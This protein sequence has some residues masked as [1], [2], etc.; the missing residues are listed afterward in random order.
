MALATDRDVLE[1][2][3]ALSPLFV[4]FGIPLDSELI[5]KLKIYYRVLMGWNTT[6]HLVAPTPPALF[7]HRHIAESLF[8][9]KFM[10]KSSTLVDIGSG[11]GL[12]AM[13]L[14]VVLKSM[15][16]VL[17]ES[18]ARKAVFLKEVAEQMELT[19]RVE[20]VADRF[21]SN[22]AP[23]ADVLTCRAIENFPE[24]VP[25]ILEWSASIA[26]RF[27]FA[28]Q[29]VV[30]RLEEAKLSFETHLIPGSEKRFLFIVGHDIDTR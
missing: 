21:E 8:A 6:L 16:G 20:V 18:S 1:F 10:T 22:D 23:D 12:P 5:L 17:F 30:N 2:E 25:T 27:L 11:G 3:E 13:P 14:L 24:L 26:K 15:R 28:G 9:S 7:A 4:D 29:S 19:K